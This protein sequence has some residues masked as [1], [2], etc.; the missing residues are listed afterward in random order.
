MYILNSA[1]SLQW[2]LYVFI[3]TIFIRQKVE[4]FIIKAN[5]LNPNL[6]RHISLNIQSF[7]VTFRLKWG[8]Y[9]NEIKFIPVVNKIFHCDIIGP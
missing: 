9:R 5:D 3:I 2:N 6:S 4:I 8:K 1:S 7:M